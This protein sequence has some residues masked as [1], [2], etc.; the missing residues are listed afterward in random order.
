MCATKDPQLI[1]KALDFTRSDVMDQDVYYFYAYLAINTLAR[2]I[3]FE[4]ALKNWDAVSCQVAV[5][6]Q[7]LRLF[8]DREEIRAE[9]RSI[10]TC[11]QGE[12]Q[13]L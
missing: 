9:F 13:I 4:D 12:L 2:R 3:V 11:L 8:L 6:L 1:Q 5:H 10:A 7:R